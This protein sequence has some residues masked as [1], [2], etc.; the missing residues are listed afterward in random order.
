MLICSRAN[1]CPEKLSVQAAQKDLRGEARTVIVSVKRDREIHT[2]TNTPHEHEFRATRLSAPFDNA[3]GI[4]PMRLF[5][6]P[7]RLAELTLGVQDFPVDLDRLGVDK[8]ESD[9]TGL[10]ATVDPIV[11]RATLHEH[12]ARFQMDNGVIELHIDFARRDDGIIDRI[13]PVVSRRHSRPKLDDAKDRPVVQCRADLPQALVSVARVI[14]GKRFRGPDHTSRRSG[15]ARDEIFGNLVDLDDRAPLV[16]MSG[17]H[18][19]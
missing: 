15:P 1:A 5:Q 18:P 13:R 2:S 10:S 7:A 12:V 16:I 19:S 14:D 6:Q 9:H 4:R 11:D 3:Q 8:D 17:D